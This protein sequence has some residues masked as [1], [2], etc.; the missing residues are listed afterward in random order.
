MEECIFCKIIA[1]EIPSQVVY[2]DDD[3]L[4]FQDINPLA[5]VHV[6]IVPKSHVS[7]L[8]DLGEEH[9]DLMGRMMLISGEIAK[10]ENIAQQGYRVTI[11]YG[12]DGGQLVPH[13]HLHLL[14]G[15]KLSGSIG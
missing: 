11:N 1:R 2:E 13:L 10:S 9:I 14:G 6:L 5:P 12:S 8:H 15:R 7:S 3:L 4:A